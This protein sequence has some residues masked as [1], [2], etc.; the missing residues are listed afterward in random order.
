MYVLLTLARVQKIGVVVCR[1]EVHA[2]KKIINTTAVS[3][4]VAGRGASEAVR[5]L[6]ELDASSTT[7]DVTMIDMTTNKTTC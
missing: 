4:F 1:G 7:T 3:C 5:G 6:G 2:Q